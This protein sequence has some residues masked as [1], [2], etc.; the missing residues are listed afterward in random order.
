M[1]KTTFIYALTCPDTGEVRYVGKADNPDA[2][3]IQHIG[4]Y[5]PSPTTKSKWIKS[6]IEAGKIPGMMILEEVSFADWSEAEKRWINHYRSINPELKN[7][8]NGGGFKRE[9]APFD[10]L[11]VRQ[12]LTPRAP[13]NYLGLGKFILTYRVTNGLTQEDLVNHTDI[14]RNYLSLIERGMATNLSVD[15]LLKLATAMQ[16]HPCE[17]LRRLMDGKGESK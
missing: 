11:K 7:S 2:R 3:F 13:L 5:D 8:S 12:A 17:L 16:I 6:V 10:L 4:L 15:V 14:S 9:K 1:T